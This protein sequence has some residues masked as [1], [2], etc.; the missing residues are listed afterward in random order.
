MRNTSLLFILYLPL[1]FFPNYVGPNKINWVDL[2]RKTQN[3][4]ILLSGG[5]YR[6]DLQGRFYLMTYNN[7]IVKTIEYS[8]K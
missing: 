4:I 7:K 6:L 1:D 2:P 8:S 3:N 5:F